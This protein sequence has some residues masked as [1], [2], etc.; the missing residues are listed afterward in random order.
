M[1]SASA[2]RCA[3]SSSS[4]NASRCVCPNGS[5]RARSASAEVVLIDQFPSIRRQENTDNTVAMR[6]H[7][8]KKPPRTTRRRL[9]KAAAATLSAYVLGRAA[10]QTTA[11]ADRR[12]RRI[13]TP[14]WLRAAPDRSRVVDVRSSK[15]V[16]GSGAYVD[17]VRLDAV[18]DR[19]LREMTGA[20]DRGRAWRAILGDARRIAIKFNSVGAG[21]INTSDAVARLLVAQLAEAGYAPDAITLVE[22]SEPLIAELGVRRPVRGWA[23]RIPVGDQSE[24]LARWFVEADTVIN[25]P[26]LK[27]HQIA[28]M[29][30]CLKNISHA[31]IRRPARYHA[32][33]CS[34]YVP[35]IVSHPLVAERLKLQVM[36][37]L[38]VVVRR[39]P[40]ATE[41][42]ISA[43][44]GVLLGYDPVAVDH[45]AW[46]IL[47]VLRR[48]RNIDGLVAVP[49]LN[50]AAE[51]RLGRAHPSRIERIG[52]EVR[53]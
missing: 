22:A 28:G 26:F 50:A 48:E 11:P 20:L 25:V 8:V 23:D 37:A 43:Y 38:R 21:V 47:A 1:S 30:G 45:V 17:S 3:S 7:S 34:P 6:D 5:S 51:L 39:G 52:L 49:Y 46:S 16:H 42:D 36:D 9:L 13:E 14:W 2:R 18:L 41:Q 53:G 44:G 32:N 33:A 29:S 4:Q 12:P 10:G 35:E 31:I 27:T 40:E 15:V 24:Q 19:A